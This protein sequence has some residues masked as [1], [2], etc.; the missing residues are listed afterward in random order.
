MNGAA[1]SG[2][3]NWHAKSRTPV[4]GGRLARRPCGSFTTLAKHFAAP[5]SAREPLSTPLRREALRP[6]TPTR[7]PRQLALGEVLRSGRVDRGV[8][9]RVP[10][11][12]SGRGAHRPPRSTPPFGP[13]GRSAVDRLSWTSLSRRVRARTK[14][15][16]A[17]VVRA[18]P[19]L[20]DPLVDERSTRH[21]R[22]SPAPSLSWVLR[23]TASASLSPPE[24]RA[25]T[26]RAR[27]CSDASSFIS[28][29]TSC[30]ARSALMWFPPTTRRRS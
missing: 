6:W 22:R 7:H 21:R 8:G 30:E 9:D 19:P 26:S 5:G 12:C 1:F 17:P 13:Q 3:W 15:M 11:G 2:G 10:G 25:R 24:P 28:P 18:A 23:A 16:G 20:V 4:C 14:H 27:Q 29:P